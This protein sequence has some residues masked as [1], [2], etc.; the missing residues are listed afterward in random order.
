MANPSPKILLQTGKEAE[1]TVL[2]LHVFRKGIGKRSI[3]YKKL[4]TILVT[5]HM[6]TQT[7]P[8]F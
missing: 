8:L 1:R 3:S 2:N 7:I 5:I 6:T 4:R